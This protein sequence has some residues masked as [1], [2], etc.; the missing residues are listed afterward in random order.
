MSV[1]AVVVV[2]LFVRLMVAAMGRGF[3]KVMTVMA[4]VIMVMVVMATVIM[5]VVMAVTVMMVMVVAVS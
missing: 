3:V 4:T 1:C 2:M 5:V